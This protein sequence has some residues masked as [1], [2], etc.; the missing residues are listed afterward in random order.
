MAE[1]AFLAL[2]HSEHPK[3]HRV[4]VIWSYGHSE[5]NRVKF[6]VSIKECNSK[7]YHGLSICMR[8]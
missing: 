4:L 6:F 5:C 7:L 3:L 8:R 2:L 1:S